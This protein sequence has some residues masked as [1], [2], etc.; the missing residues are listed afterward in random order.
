MLLL[1]ERLLLLLPRRLLSRLPL[2]ARRTRG[3]RRAAQTQ[4]RPLL[5][6]RRIR[7]AHQ[8]PRQRVRHRG[9]LPGG[10]CSCSCPRGSPLLVVRRGGLR[11]GRHRPQRRVGVGRARKLD[12][13]KVLGRARLPVPRHVALDE[14]AVP[15]RQ[16]RRQLRRVAEDGPQV[17][18]V[19][20]AGEELR[21]QARGGP[22]SVREPRRQPPLLLLLL[23]LPL[24]RVPLLLLHLPRPG[25]ALPAVG[26]HRRL[27]LVQGRL[28]PR[29]GRGDRELDEAVPLWFRAPGGGA[30]RR[31]GA[32]DVPEPREVRVDPARVEPL[33]G[34]V[35]DEELDPR[36]CCCC[37]GGGG[38]A[39]SGE[40]ERASASVR[41]S[42]SIT[43]RRRRRPGA[44]PS[45]PPR[46]RRP[47]RGA[48]LPRRRRHRRRGREG[49]G[50]G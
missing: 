35:G 37:G 29:R 50:G 7:K 21:G 1:L 9:P 8:R 39:E 47:C 30:P 22:L 24:A 33:P 2:R 6:L 45:P 27:E 26:P 11:R 44:A 25:L 32:D 5:Q 43:P 15:A 41:P 17:L 31:Q 36:G 3:R 12:K 23:L 46:P 10:C 20:H 13:R 16:R 38:G 14:R 42:G 40:D 18:E 34:G 28:G 49:P 48:L 4:P 19:E